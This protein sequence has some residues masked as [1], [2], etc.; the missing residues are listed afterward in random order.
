MLRKN[1]YGTVE[2]QRL[3]HLMVR[4]EPRADYSKT[5]PTAMVRIAAG[6]IPQYIALL[7]GKAADELLSILL[8]KPFALSRGGN[9][10]FRPILGYRPARNHNLL[11]EQP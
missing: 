1:S 4:E 2:I 10:F 8:K 3:A 7:S 9:M 11:R 6:R 5:D